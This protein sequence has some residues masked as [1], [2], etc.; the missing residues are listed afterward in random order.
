MVS[1]VAVVGPQEASAAERE[2]AEAVGRGLASAGCVVVTG[3]L[4]GVMA[5]AASGAAAAG[6]TSVG[7]LP[8]DD[9]TEAAGSLTIS[10][11]TGLGEARNPLV[12]RSADAVIAV[13]GSWGTLSEI[14]F[15]MT[16][17]AQ[18]RNDHGAIRRHAGVSRRYAHDRFGRS[19]SS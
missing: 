3:G 2:I 19:W 9:R 12:V 8:G 5:S 18:F 15:A 17:S 1:Y 4:G 16:T 10:I 6:G 13:G 14:A 7:L 11:P